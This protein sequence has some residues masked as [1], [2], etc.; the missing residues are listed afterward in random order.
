MGNFLG[1]GKKDEFILDF[2]GVRTDVSSTIPYMNKLNSNAQL[3]ANRLNSKVMVSQKEFNESENYDMYKL[4]EKTQSLDNNNNNFSDTSPFISSDVYKNLINTQKGG[5]MDDDI[6]S[7]ESSDSSNSSSSFS[8]SEK[9]RSKKGK[10]SSKASG[11]ASGKA[12]KT[13]KKSKKSSEKA[14]P[15]KS[16]SKHSKK[17]R[18]NK[19]KEMSEEISEES[20]TSEDRTN[21]GKK[22]KKDKNH[23]MEDDEEEIVV[24]EDVDSLSTDEE[25]DNVISDTMD[26]I[27]V[28][29]ASYLSSSDHDDKNNKY[30]NRL[31]SD[32][33]NTSDINMISVEE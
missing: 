26:D 25:I 1:L 27:S 29:G 31:L 15:V 33:I 4:F 30:K 22:D 21:K 8:S 9:P 2:E 11:K 16:S 19:G 3:L 28:G 17:S 32:S 6:S 5:N 12:K 23:D 14:A 20:S 18:K 13:S 7:T 10:A 24:E